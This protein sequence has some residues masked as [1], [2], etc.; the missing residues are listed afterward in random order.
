MASYIAVYFLTM[1][2]AKYLRRIDWTADSRLYSL[3]T[4]LDG[5]SYIIV[6][7]TKSEFSEPETLIFGA[8]ERG[9]P[10]DFEELPG[11]CVGS[12]NHDEAIIKA[13]YTPF[14]N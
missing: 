1:K 12:I 3:S 6:T 5:H 14:Y 13:G 10:I 11:T 4:K 9:N 8:D 2:I 7:A